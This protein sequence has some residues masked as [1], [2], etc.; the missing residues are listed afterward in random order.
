MY[1]KKV[2]YLTLALVL[3]AATGSA[4]RIHTLETGQNE[5]QPE[6]KVD[7]SG[8]VINDD[9][10]PIAD[11]QVELAVAY[12]PI[13]NPEQA[14]RET[15][16]HRVFLPLEMNTDENRYVNY[17]WTVPE[18][19][20]PGSYKIYFR[21]LNANEDLRVFNTE[22]F[23]VTD[24]GQEVRAA[25]IDELYFHQGDGIGVSLEG[26]RVSSNKSADATMNVS[27]LG[28]VDLTL[29]MTMDMQ[30]TFDRTRSAFKQYEQL[31]VPAGETET[32]V[33]EFMPPDQ[34]TTYTPVFQAYDSEGTLLGEKKGRLVVRGNSGR[35][36]R[37]GI[38]NN[39]YRR[40]ETINI[41]ADL[42]GPA[43]YSGTIPGT[44]FNYTIEDKNGILVQGRKTVDIG[45]Q[46]TELRFQE[47]ASRSFANP[48]VTMVLSKDGNV[49][50]RY[51][52]SYSGGEVP[53]SGFPVRTVLGV[54][55]ILI[56]A[57]LLVW[58]WKQ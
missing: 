43:D 28:N 19:A 34:P 50:D 54:V 53:D 21:I 38:D 17:S 41:R 58:R 31:T 29:N 42:V 23:N 3:L 11:H 56:A 24:T 57:G 18:N 40:G 44:T 5:Y 37:A 26:F 8:F 20:P 27:N 2:I 9:G 55:I 49:Y 33:F 7:I 45:G 16:R 46:I 10:E 32:V 25:T 35:I 6:Q 52:A 14:T 36:L 51:T 13:Y 22:R 39:T 48:N 1:P 47:E 30:Y 4:L 12:S 15:I